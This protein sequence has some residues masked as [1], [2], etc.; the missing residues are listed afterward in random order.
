MAKMT[1]GRHSMGKTTEAE[2]S[3]ATMTVGRRSIVRR[4]EEDHHTTKTTGAGLR[5][6]ARTTAECLHHI[7]K[8]T[9]ADHILPHCRPENQS[10]H[11]KAGL[12]CPTTRHLPCQYRPRTTAGSRPSQKTKRLFGQGVRLRFRDFIISGTATS[13]RTSRS[14]CSSRT[15]WATGPISTTQKASSCASQTNTG[16]LGT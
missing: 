5:S 9:V 8:R 16:M 2:H 10:A 15:S 11:H 6:I 3:I 12:A 1:V 4:T 14:R 13:S 7:H